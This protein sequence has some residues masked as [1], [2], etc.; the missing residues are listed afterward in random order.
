MHGAAHATDGFLDDSQT[1]T[2]SL[3]LLFGMKTLKY[4]ENLL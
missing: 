1:D 2:C 3:V 4:L